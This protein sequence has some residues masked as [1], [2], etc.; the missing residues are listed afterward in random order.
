MPL[1]EF[2]I[3]ESPWCKQFKIG[4]E[5]GILV[6]GNGTDLDYFV[7]IPPVKIPASNGKEINSVICSS[8]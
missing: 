2:Q 8:R 1:K 3:E 5:N 6:L 4:W 7:K